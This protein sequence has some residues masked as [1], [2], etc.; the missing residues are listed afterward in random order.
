[1]KVKKPLKY[2][3]FETSIQ[4]ENWQMSTNNNIHQLQPL[5]MSGGIKENQIEQMTDFTM[6]VGVFVLYSEAGEQDSE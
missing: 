2:K 6:E 4:F 1:M 5:V 3:F